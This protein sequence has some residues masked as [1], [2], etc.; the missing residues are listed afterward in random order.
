MTDPPSAD[1]VAE[2]VRYVA[3]TRLQNRYAD[4]V[5]RREWDELHE[6]FLPD[7]RVE[8][9]KRSGDPLVLDGPQAV[10]GFIGG[11]IA[12]FEFFEFVILSTVVEVGVDGDDTR[13]QGRMYIHELRQEAGGRWTDA[14]GVYHDRYREVDG[15]WWF[16]ARR[17]HSLARTAPDVQ[18][19]GFPHHLR[20][21]GLEDG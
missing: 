19:F 18:V 10:G 17:Y 16:E 3:I 11:A 9:D 15:R 12:D 1:A 5:T 13:A 7:A 2:T 14:Y 21:G 4:I 20:L 6:I 8:V